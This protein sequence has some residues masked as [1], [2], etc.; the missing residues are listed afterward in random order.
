MTP[1]SS[2]LLSLT[3]TQDRNGRPLV[4][5]KKLWLRPLGRRT[6]AAGYSGPVCDRSFFSS[7]QS[8]KRT[9]FGLP[10]CAAAIAGC[11]LRTA[12]QPCGGATVLS[13]ARSR[14][15]SRSCGPR[16]AQKI[17]KAD[18][19][20]QM[21]RNILDRTPSVE[22]GIELG[23]AG[24]KHHQVHQEIEKQSVGQAPCH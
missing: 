19:H 5:F 24:R 16:A 4:A 1:F 8:R 18:P 22:S 13:F 10:A 9:D 14:T 20:R 12:Q 21:C 6:A 3:S 23:P 7:I 11:N 17:G 15:L 2:P